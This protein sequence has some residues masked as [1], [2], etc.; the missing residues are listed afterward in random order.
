LVENESLPQ[1]LRPVLQGTVR[2]LVVVVLTCLQ[3]TGS[4]V[5]TFWTALVSVTA[6]GAVGFIAVCSVLSNMLC[7]VL[8]VVFD[9]FRIGEEIEVIEATG[10]KGPRGTV[11]NLN[12]LYTSL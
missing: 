10:G 8:L 1:P 4:R 12:V 7:S 9:L 6:L 3:Q 11:V 2:W 5:A